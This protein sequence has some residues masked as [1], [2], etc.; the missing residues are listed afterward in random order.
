[1]WIMYKHGILGGISLRLQRRPCAAFWSIVP[2]GSD[3]FGMFQNIVEGRYV[4]W[5]LLVKDM[6]PDRHQDLDF[7]IGQ[8]DWEKNVD[9]NFKDSNYLEPIV[10]DQGDGWVD[11]WIVYG[12]VDGQQLFSARELTVA[13]G[14]SS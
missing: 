7:I 9:P 5:S 4:P 1:M 8:L 2:F 13:P 11:R 6:P 12:T 14:A 10:A 3:V